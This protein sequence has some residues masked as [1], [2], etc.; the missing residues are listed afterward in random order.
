MIQPG[1]SANG[2]RPA[3]QALHATMLAFLTT[4]AAVAAP[5]L[6]SALSAAVAQSFNR[7]TVDGDPSFTC[8]LTFG[9][10]EDYSEQGM[11]ATTMRV[12]NAIPYVCNAPP[13]LVSSAD[14]PALLPRHAFETPDN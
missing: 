6:R 7:I 12:V 2:Q 9:T 1:M 14:L 8:E 11:I 3:A 10:A 5:V 4:D 13:G